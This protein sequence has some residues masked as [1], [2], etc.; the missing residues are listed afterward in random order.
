MT[1]NYLWQVELLDTHE[2]VI[3]EDLLSHEI[4]C[5]EVDLLNSDLSEETHLILKN[6]L[7]SLNVLFIKVKRAV[8]IDG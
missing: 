2:T 3:L 4:H 6:R 7:D 1:K 8:F 5:C